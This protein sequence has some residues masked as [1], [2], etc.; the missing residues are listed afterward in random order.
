MTCLPLRFIR[1]LTEDTFTLIGR[2][3]RH[4]TKTLSLSLTKISPDKVSPDKVSHISF[5]V[6]CKPRYVF[7]SLGHYE[8]IIRFSLEE[9][10]RKGRT[11]YIS[12]LYLK[13]GQFWDGKFQRIRDKSFKKYVTILLLVAL[14]KF[15]EP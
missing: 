4:Q 10:S 2:N 12:Y 7:G 3:F 11:V 1:T 15:E 6:F 13:L 5:R 8:L 14:H 9:F